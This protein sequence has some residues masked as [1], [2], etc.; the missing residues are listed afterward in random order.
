M[1]PRAERNGVRTGLGGNRVV[2]GDCSDLAGYIF[3]TC[4]ITV[5]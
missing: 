3:I 5:G 2:V 1:E 4:A